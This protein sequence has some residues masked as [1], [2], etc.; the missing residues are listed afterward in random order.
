VFQLSAES[1]VI[2]PSIGHR[3]NFI[4]SIKRF[5]QCL[6]AVVPL[7]A[8]QVSVSVIWLA[9]MWHHVSGIWNIR[10]GRLSQF[11]YSPVHF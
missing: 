5:K 2:A 3:G 9:E 11:S 10:R 4:N 8:I 6:A 7:L 1:R